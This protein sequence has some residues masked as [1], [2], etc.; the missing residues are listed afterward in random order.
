MPNKQSVYQAFVILSAKL[1]DLR[2]KIHEL[3][4]RLVI[5]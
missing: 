4:R 3:R 2:V 1:N 5:L